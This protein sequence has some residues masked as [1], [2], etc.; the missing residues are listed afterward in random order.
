MAGGVAQFS[1]GVLILVG[2]LVGLAGVFALFFGLSE[3]DENQEGLFQDQ[4]ESETNQAL[5]VAGGAGMLVGLV[6]AV[7]GIAFVVGGQ[8][9]RDKAQQQ[10]VVLA[11]GNAPVTASQQQGQDGGRSWAVSPA[12]LILV[13]GALLLMAITL[14]A[15][16][17]DGTGLLGSDGPVH[18]GA[19]SFE[20]EYSGLG[21]LA[22]A[23]DQG[24]LDL[25]KGTQYVDAVLE[26]NASTFGTDSFR[27]MLEQNIGGMWSVVEQSEGTSPVMLTWEVPM[28]SIGELR[29][30]VEP[31]SS[32]PVYDQ[33]YLA[34]FDYWDD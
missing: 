18:L 32:A 25:P 7:V 8:A 23:D 29:F 19:Q 24:G 2:V 22:F 4:E 31:T 15:F 9:R 3:E 10:A 27:F 11:A 13:V 1:G 17:G 33:A 14:A 12:V 30:R 34:Q 6:V 20:G 21:G 26:W 16:N 28:L 5:V